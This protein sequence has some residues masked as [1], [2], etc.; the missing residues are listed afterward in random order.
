MSLL[1]KLYYTNIVFIDKTI[2]DSLIEQQ[3]KLQPRRQSTRAN[4]SL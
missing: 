1:Y 3:Q 2:I 4:A